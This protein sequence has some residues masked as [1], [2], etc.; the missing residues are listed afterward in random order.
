MPSTKT[1][2]KEEEFRPTSNNL[3]IRCIPGDAHLTTSRIYLNNQLIKNGTG[4]VEAQPDIH[5]ND[6]F[7]IVST[8]NKPGNQS[9]FASITVIFENQGSE[10]RWDFSSP[11]HD[12]TEVIYQIKIQII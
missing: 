6:E 4:I 9:D 12:Y 11:E 5:Q 1:I 10:R 3:K 2:Q 8:I 7:L